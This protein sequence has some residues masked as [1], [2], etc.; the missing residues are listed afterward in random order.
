MS[1]SG[2]ECRNRVGG[3]ERVEVE[4]RERKTTGWWEVGGMAEVGSKQSIAGINRH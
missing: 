2:I 1:E 3:G 4:E